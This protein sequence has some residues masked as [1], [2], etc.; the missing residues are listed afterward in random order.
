LQ[1]PGGTALFIK[2]VGEE[3]NPDSPV[4]HRR[5]AKVAASLPMSSAWPHLLETYDDGDWV[6]LAF[7]AIDGRPPATPWR[8]EELEAVVAALERMHHALTPS[9]TDV[10]PSAALRLADTFGGWERIADN[11][12]ETQRLDG[13]SRANLSRLVELESTW[14]AACAGKT[15]LHCDIRS[16]NVL[17]RPDGSVVFVDWPH[18]SVGAPTL[19]LV[20]WA[21]S[22]VLEGGPP[23]E[24]LLALHAPS[25]QIDP[26]D[27]ACMVA[28]VSG[29]LLHGSLKPPPPGL[30]TLRP[31]QAAQGEVARA[32]LQRCTGW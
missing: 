25:R 22:V 4:F 16:D 9:P 13:W 24:E 28:A 7:Q 18:A 3:L 30:P 17:I 12:E 21:P 19:D 23:P 10:V 5:E 6:A 29:F 31:F 8:P 20:C 11:P 27:L 15:L 1:F 2:A 14:Q 32:W 26:A